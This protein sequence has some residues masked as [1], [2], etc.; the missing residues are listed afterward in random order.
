MKKNK[1]NSI[2]L[3]FLLHIYIYSLVYV[4]L[5]DIVRFYIEDRFEIK[6]LFITSLASPLYVLYFGDI[7]FFILL[8]PFFYIVISHY[9]KSTHNQFKIYIISTAL[10]NSLMYLIMFFNSR[11]YIKLLGRINNQDYVIDKLFFMIP[12]LLVAIFLN[13]MIFKR[14]YKRLKMEKPN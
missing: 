13:K 1:T 4:L 7:P 10:V 2:F 9:F 3:L 6:E 14:N 12:S 5:Y 11:N 8:I